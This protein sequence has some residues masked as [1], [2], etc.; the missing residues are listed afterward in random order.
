MIQAL[1][2]KFRDAVTGVVVDETEIIAS[3]LDGSMVTFDIRA[4]RA[5]TDKS[6]SPII[7]LALS[8]NREEILV[9]LLGHS[10][11][12]R[13]LE[14]SSGKT[15]GEFRGH[16]NE[17]FANGCCFDHQDALVWSGSED[18]IVRAWHRDTSQNNL[19]L[20]LSCTAAVIYVAHHPRIALLCTAAT[21]G[22]V[23]VWDGTQV[24]AA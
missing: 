12:L 20:E 24:E 17:Q 11:A 19:A 10:A 9:A 7:A 5:I 8:R 4:G 15:L 3:S 22:C 23:Q 6:N 1:P 13:V 21:D 16:V 14:R 2:T 18:G